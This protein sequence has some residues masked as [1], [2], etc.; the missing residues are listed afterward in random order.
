MVIEYVLK[1][2]I[3]ATILACIQISYNTLLYRQFGVSRWIKFII[4]SLFSV[5]IGG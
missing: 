2:L 5:G 1:G 4:I 3:I